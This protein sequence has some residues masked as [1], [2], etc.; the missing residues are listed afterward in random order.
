M[1]RALVAN[2]ASRWD[3]T[4]FKDVYRENLMKIIKARL[5]GKAPKLRAEAEPQQAEVVDLMER[6]RQRLQGARGR[7]AAGGRAAKKT[8]T[9][10]KKKRH[11]A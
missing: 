1:A 2:L 4:R 11:A 8:A 10:A 3:P 6:L 9:R 7:K 5:K